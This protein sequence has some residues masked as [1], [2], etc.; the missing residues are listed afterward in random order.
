VV[1]YESW[2][3]VTGN[4]LD[5]SYD[6]FSNLPDVLYQFATICVAAAEINSTSCPL[7]LPSMKTPDP[8]RDIVGRVYAV[9]ETLASNIQQYSSIY[10][11]SNTYKGNID[12]ISDSLADP[13]LWPS[14]ATF[15]LGLEDL[16][17][18][19]SSNHKKRH[20]EPT[21]FLLYSPLDPVAG[22]TSFANFN[23]RAAIMPLD[24][25]YTNIANASS[26]V[27][28]ILKQIEQNSFIAYGGLDYA[29]GLGW[30]DATDYNVERF[31]GPFPSQ[32]NNKIVII[33]RTY[34]AGHP[35]KSALN[36]YEFIGSD[37]AV[38]L[39]HDGFGYLFTEDPN[40]CINDSIKSYF[41]KGMLGFLTK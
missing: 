38:L 37:N 33:S 2:M 36:T 20:Q 24:S 39:V 10:N 28:Y 31:T 21:N 40:D 19:K 34:N 22:L 27:D 25:N 29:A 12:D 41:T 3:G 4:V 14:L 35:P 17:A 23:A 15:I 7:A 13:K 16:V 1:D 8:A 9:L 18:Q 6:S 30:P 11:G 26:F 5:Y 32:T